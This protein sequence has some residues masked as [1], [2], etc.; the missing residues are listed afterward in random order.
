VDVVIV[1]AGLS[2]VGAAR[3]LQDQCP[4]ASFVLLESRHAVG[5]TWDLFRYP[6]IRSDSDMF[7]L[8]YSFKPWRGSKSIAP[9]AEIRDYIVETATETGVMDH[10]RFGHRVRRL[11]WSSEAGRWRVT[12]ERTDGGGP[13][14]L[15]A[16]FVFSCT[17]YYR[18]DHGYEPAF[19]GRDC[20]GGTVVHPQHWPEDLDYAGRKVVVIGSG[21]TAVTLVP[22]LAER[23]AHVTMLQRSPSYVASLPAEDKVANVLRRVL[24]ARA[25]GPLVRT[26]KALLSQ[27]FYEFCRRWPVRARAFLRRGLER[28]LPAGY[29]IDTHFTPRYDPWDQRLCLV[30]DADLFR[31]IR[32]GT[33]EVVTDQIET[34]TETGLRLDSGRELEADLVVT[35]TGLE[36]LFLGGMEVV[37]DGE[38]VDLP[39]RLVYKG[40]MVEGVPNL[41]VAIGY[42]NASWTLK[43]DLTCRY[44]CRVLNRLHDQGLARVA[45]VARQPEQSPEPLLALSSG[46]IRR[47]ADRLPRQGAAPPWR[48]EQSWLR[49]VR[50]LRLSGLDDGVLVFS[51]PQR[52]PSPSEARAA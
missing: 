16:R 45:P 17:G 12:A 30:P 5:G 27:G 26:M 6:G 47:A 51:P 14:E 2:G 49:D 46:Y 35:A 15:S 32:R 19:P 39:S 36:V 10:I 11:D 8:G 43:C 38:A 7:T 1:G 31:A 18:Y 22:A 9:G 25:S 40:M 4:W 33:V 52:A 34:F 3:Y 41:A 24:P 28:M 20:F 37:V 13:V 42:T 44:V 48:V 23:A 21:A 29:D 50:A